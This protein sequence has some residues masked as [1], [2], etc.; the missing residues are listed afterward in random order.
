MSVYKVAIAMI[1]G[2]SLLSPIM[3]A[4]I[5]FP[6]G[7][8][9]NDFGPI[10]RVGEYKALIKE[11]GRFFVKQTTVFYENE[12]I[13][14]EYKN[15]FAFISDPSIKLGDI[16]S[17]HP[18]TSEENDFVRI[19][20]AKIAL[21]FNGIK[22][23]I[24]EKSN[25]LNIKTKYGHSILYKGR[26]DFTLKWAGDLDSDGKLDFIVY[27]AEGEYNAESCLLL[28]GQAEKGSVVSESACQ[29]YSG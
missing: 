1:L 24:F 18:F 29:S 19:S 16:E 4:E 14:S 28:S 22:Y 25:S 6:G 7:A 12:I 11:E 8:D 21:H 27:S 23:T 13:Y 20:K 15:A 2:T 3:A 26:G 17:M 9:S 5:I 10:G